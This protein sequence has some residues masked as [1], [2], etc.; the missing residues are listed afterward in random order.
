MNSTSERTLRQQRRWALQRNQERERKQ[1]EKRQKVE[2][3][4]E[5]E[6]D[7]NQYMDMR[8]TIAAQ[9]LTFLRVRGQL[10]AA[11]R[12]I[13]TLKKEK[14]ELQETLEDFRLDSAKITRSLQMD[15]QQERNISQQMAEYISNLVS[16]L[17]EYKTQNQ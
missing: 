10:D 8:E 6:Y 1:Q 14:Q 9:T 12:E 11:R 3:V 4:K 17:N 15:L 5:K 2:E 13:E 7:D 16:E